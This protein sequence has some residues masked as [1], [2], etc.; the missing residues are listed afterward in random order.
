APTTEI[1]PLS[2]HDA[3]PISGDFSFALS[4]APNGSTLREQFW[5]GS[6]MDR[7]INSAATEQ[8][9][10]RGVHNCIDVQLGDVAADDIDLSCGFRS[11]EHTSELQSR[12]D[13]VCR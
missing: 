1:Y 10:I 2:L 11:E 3:L 5:S 6:A 4:A 8:R 9:R 7:A 12:F 13:L